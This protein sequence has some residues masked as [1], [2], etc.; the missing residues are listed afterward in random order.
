MYKFLKRLHISPYLLVVLSF[1]LLIVIGSIFLW[2]PISHV[3]GQSP[4]YV[5]AFFMSVSAVC[6]T[7]LSVY[8]S[9]VET[10]SDFGKVVLV[11]LIQLGGLG[12]ISIFTFLITLVGRKLNFTDRYIIKEALNYESF[13]GVT[14]FVRSMVIISLIAEVLGTIPFLFVFIPDYGIYG[15]IGRAIFHSISSFNNA[16]FDLIGSTSLQP[17]A[18]NLIVNINTMVLVIIGGLGFVV[19]ADLARK[20]KAKNWAT[21]TKVVVATTLVLITAGTLGIYLLNLGKITFLQALF[22]SVSARTAGFATVDLST[23]SNPSQMLIMIL[24]FIGASPL[25]TGGG[26]KTTTAFI[27]VLTIFFFIRGKKTHSFKRTFPHRNF[28]QATTL[29]FM[30][31]ATLAIAVSLL[32]LFETNAPF[33]AEFGPESVL[34]EAISAFGTVGFSYGITPSL[35]TGSKIVLT[36]LMFFGRVGP[37]TMMSIVSEAMNKEEKLHYQYIETNIIVG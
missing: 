22:Q 25:S 32:E 16:G 12:F 7:G 14:K 34:F 10:F 20:R 26:V 24:M 15:G 1:L 23:L 31:F 11:I 9:V 29:V 30:S 21:L 5:D 6:V 19:I 35:T 18:S 33:M 36:V 28:I 8:A 13:R 37:M 3:S 27:I 17:Y 4:N 2:L